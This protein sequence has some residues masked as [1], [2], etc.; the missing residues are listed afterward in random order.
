MEKDDSDEDEMKRVLNQNYE[1][2][3][4]M[5]EEAEEEQ[6]DEEMQ[7]GSDEEDIS[8]ESAEEEQEDVMDSGSEK[9]VGKKRTLKDRLKEEQSIRAKEKEMR[10]GDAQPKDIDDFERLLIANQDQ[11]YL[12]IQYIAFMLDNLGVEAARKVA[13]RAIKA[14]SM[15][16]EEDKL[17]IWTAFMNLESNFGSQE[18]LE[19]VTKRALDVN[20][21]RQ[22]YAKLIE[23]YKQNQSFEYIEPIYKQLVKKFSNNIDLW[24]RYLEFLFEMRSLQKEKSAIALQQTFTEPKLLL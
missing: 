16:N 3:K 12:W 1:S 18:T 5:S 13:E 7:V 19:S 11:S 10:S 8:D 23:I 6:S 20:D 9:L 21:R 14:V 2:D 4:S 24:S 17:N 22:V 15:S